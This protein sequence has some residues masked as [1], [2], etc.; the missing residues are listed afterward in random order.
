MLPH[1]ANLVE[2]VDTPGIDSKDT[3]VSEWLPHLDGLILVYAADSVTSLLELERRYAKVIT[4]TLN[5]EM[6]TIPMWVSFSLFCFSNILVVLCFVLKAM[7]PAPA[8]MF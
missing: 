4:Q 2:I 6:H 3:I 8:A 7:R 5:K 1:Q